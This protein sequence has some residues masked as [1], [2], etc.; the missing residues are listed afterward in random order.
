MFNKYLTLIGRTFIGTFLAVN[1][2]NIIPLNFSSNAWLSQVSTLFVDTG[3]LLLLGLV[4]LKICHLILFKN[5]SNNKSLD[6]LDKDNISLEQEK[7]SI[8]FI[9][10]CSRYFMI[11]FI[12]LG[13][14]QSYLF[15]NGLSYINYEYSYSYQQIDNKYIKQKDKIESNSENLESI[16]E[17]LNAL[18]FKKNNYIKELQKTVSRARFMLFKNNLKV[19]IMSLIWTFGF[20]KLSKLNNE[21]NTD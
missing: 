6:I 12:V 13:I 18:K 5:F 4:C 10:K 3:S 1:F 20:F 16:N 8:N 21:V 11:F 14:S 19:I 15:I 9:N 7:R 17:E 2:F